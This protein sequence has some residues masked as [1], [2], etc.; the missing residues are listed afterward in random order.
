MD[1]FHYIHLSDAHVDIRGSHVAIFLRYDG[2]AG[3]TTAVVINFLDGRWSRIVEE[4]VLRIREAIKSRCNADVNAEPP[5]VHLIYLSSIIRWWNNVLLYFNQQLIAHEKRLQDDMEKS[6]ST[7]LDLNT[8]INKA[9]HIMAAH[10]HSYSSK[11]ERLEDILREFLSRYEKPTS[12]IDMGDGDAN[13]AEQT[14]DWNRV[15][16]AFE[17]IL[18]RL[19]AI[20]VFGKELESK[21]ENILAL[22]FNQIQVTNDRTMQ[23]ILQAAQKDASASHKVAVS[24]KE[25]SIAMKTQSFLVMLPRMHKTLT[26]FALTG[27]S[28]NAIL[29]EK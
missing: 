25:D 15:K 26:F 7:N 22:L 1:P 2:E 23:A 9:L 5:F 8:V 27:S 14:H 20:R 18:S 4:P 28:V 11:L 12:L 21:I 13:D 10:L 6:D 3:S 24:M 29:P 16:F 17:Q 19:K